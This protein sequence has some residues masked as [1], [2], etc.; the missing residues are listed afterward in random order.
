MTQ[1]IVEYRR[2]EKE[3]AATPIGAAFL[4]FRAAFQS[5]CVADAKLEYLD[6]GDKAAREAW[7]R[8]DQAEKELRLLIGGPTYDKTGL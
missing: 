6:K 3:F 7:A 4:K 5:A 1:D 2:K 8:A